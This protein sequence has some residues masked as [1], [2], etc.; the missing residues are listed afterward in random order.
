ML[1]WEGRFGTLPGKTT[2]GSPSA[3]RGS[4]RTLG[5]RASR[6]AGPLGELRFLNRRE[7]D[8]V[9]LHA[10]YRPAAGLGAEDS[11]PLR[12]ILGS[13][14]GLLVIPQGH[15]KHLAALTIGE[16]QASTETVLHLEC[17]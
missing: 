11:Q 13:V 9:S 1:V 15:S 6:F 8:L 16:D 12:G 4:R 10:T 7:E 2:T 5:F 14:H 3:A 17:R